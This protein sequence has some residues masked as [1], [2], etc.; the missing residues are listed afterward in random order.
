M[1]IRSK[2]HPIHSWAECSAPGTACFRP[3]PRLRAA[4]RWDLCSR[5]ALNGWKSHGWK[6]EAWP[7]STLERAML[8]CV[9]W[10]TSDMIRIQLKGLNLPSTGQQRSSHLIVSAPGSSTWSRATWKGAKSITTR[11]MTDI[12]QIEY[13]NPLSAEW[14]NR[15]KYAS[16]EKKCCLRQRM[17]TVWRLRRPSSFQPPGPT[18]KA[19]TESGSLPPSEYD[20]RRLLDNRAQTRQ[21]RSESTTTACT[22]WTCKGFRRI[23]LFV[24]L[25]RSPHL[26]QILGGSSRCLWRRWWKKLLK[27]QK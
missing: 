7:A 20:R 19:W 26:N 17:N 15:T 16:L 4:R 14:L 1:D 11:G 2:G 8:T 9:L 6:M 10:K 3:K 25:L 23:M 22:Q 24:L 21:S 12:K 13:R 18:T 27:C 5:L